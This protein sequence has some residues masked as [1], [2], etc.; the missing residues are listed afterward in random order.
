MGLGRRHDSKLDTS[1]PDQGLDRARQPASAPLA[2]TDGPD[3]ACRPRTS[4]STTIEVTNPLRA[5]LD[6]A[7]AWLPTHSLAVAPRPPPDIALGALDPAGR[8]AA[9]PAAHADDSFQRAQREHLRQLRRFEFPADMALSPSARDLVGLDLAGRAQPPGAGSSSSLA[10]SV[11]AGSAGPDAPLGGD[12]VIMASKLPLRLLDKDTVIDIGMQLCDDG[13]EFDPPAG[14]HA[15]LFGSLHSHAHT[16]TRRPDNELLQRRHAVHDDE[17]ALLDFGGEPVRRLAKKV[18]FNE[19]VQE[20]PH[21]DWTRR[22]EL[23]RMQRSLRG[24]YHTCPCLFHRAMRGIRRFFSCFGE[25]S[26]LDAEDL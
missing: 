1:E 26:A 16:Q 2:L 9:L 8:V 25:P 18:S 5:G 17:D 6:A 10:S 22:L 21:D 14:P 4:A 12:D 7:V 3:A 11:P 24:P 19:E 15:P 13:H 23:H 20:F